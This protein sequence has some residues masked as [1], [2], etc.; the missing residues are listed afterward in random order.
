MIQVGTKLK[1]I[2]NSG[3]KDVSCI[4][5]LSKYRQRYAFLGDVIT[6]S[7]QNLR[8][9]RKVDSKVKKGEVLKALVL[10]TKSSIKNKF[11]NLYFF[12]NSVILLNKQNKLVGTRIFGPLPKMLRYSKHMRLVSLSSGILF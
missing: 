10:Y 7:I 12:E 4:G 8:S 11:S 5:V 6:V 1:V 3:A 2:D 9:Q